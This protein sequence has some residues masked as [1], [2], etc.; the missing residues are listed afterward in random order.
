MVGLSRGMLLAG[1]ALVLHGSPWAQEPP[2]PEATSGRAERAAVE[3]ERFMIATANGRATEAGAAVLRHGGGAVD[4]MVAAQL[5]LNLVEPQSSGIGGGAFMLYWDAKAR[6]LSTFDGRE[7]APLAVGPDLFLKADGTAMAFD[8]AVAGGRSV[9]V[10]GTLALLEL[11]HR[12]HGRLPWAELVKPAAELAD[13]GFAVSPRLAGAIA[14]N[15]ATFA[16]FATTRAYF[17]AADGSPRASGTDLRNPDFA[18]TLRAIAAEGSAPLYRGR[19]GDALVAAVRGAPVNPGAMT[20]EDLARYRVLLREPIC[21]PYRTFEVCGMGPPS[22]RRADRRQILGM[23]AHFDLAALG[24]GR[25]RHPRLSSK[26]AS[27]PSPTATS[28]SPT[29]TSYV[30]EGLLDP[31]YLTARAQL[32]DPAP[33]DGEGRPGEPPWRKASSSPLTASARTTAPAIS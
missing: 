7:T 25:R 16:P 2:A 29:A 9:G 14:D 26:P 10:P 21:R 31:G 19:I 11:A 13:R 30:P 12:L 28:T 20:A 18:Q 33:R 6:R 27:S 32:I 17:L 8:E 24:P 4:A 23:L 1:L 22:S 3:V 15:A 5:T